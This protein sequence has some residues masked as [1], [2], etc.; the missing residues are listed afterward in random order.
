MNFY[1][2]VVIYEKIEPIVPKPQPLAQEAGKVYRGTIG[3][4]ELNNIL[5]GKA[6]YIEGEIG[7]MWAKTPEDALKY[8]KGFSQ[9]TGMASLKP[10]GEGAYLLEGIKKSTGEVIPISAKNINTGKIINLQATKGVKVKVPAEG[11]VPKVPLESAIT[12]NIPEIL[13]KLP[14]QVSQKV[15][16]IGEELTSVQKITNALK[17]A[18][19]IRGKQ[20]ALYT[21]ERGAKMAK[22]LAVGEKATG[23]AGFYAELGQLKGELPKAQFESIKSK[24]SP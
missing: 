21:A 15:P 14:P 23:E 2:K 6:K 13:P 3:T 20:E 17:E 22:A 16:Q 19:P 5:S 24:L 4:G 11:L 12:K 18:K 8:A 9:T 1:N 7:G 10:T